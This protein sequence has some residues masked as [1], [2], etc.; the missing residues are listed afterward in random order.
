M[1]F[2]NL[3]NS[4]TKSSNCWSHEVRWFKYKHLVVDLLEWKLQSIR[5]QTSKLQSQDDGDAT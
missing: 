3:S 2:G 4:N 5:L 1:Q